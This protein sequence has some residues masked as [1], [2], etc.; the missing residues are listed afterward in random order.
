MSEADIKTGMVADGR[1]N[2]VKRSNLAHL[3]MGTMVSR[4]LDKA[5]MRYEK[6]FG[7]ECVKYAPKRMMCRDRRAK[8]LM[9]ENERDFFVLDVHEVADIRTPQAMTN[10]WGFSVAEAAEVD[11]IRQ[12]AVEHADELGFDTIHPALK[13]HGSYSFYMFDEDHNWWEVECRLGATNDMFFS[14]GDW[15]SDT[16]DQNPVVDPALKIAHTA[17]DVM[18]DEAF[19]THGTTA[20]IACDETRPFYEDILK[21]RT[22]WH[23]RPS[24]CFAGGGD[25]GVIGV[26]SG[27][28]I[29][30]QTPDNRFVLIVDDDKA[31]QEAHDRVSAAREPYGLLEVTDIEPGALDGHGFMLR[32]RDHVWFEISSRSRDTLREIFN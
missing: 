3:A 17:T 15:N 31:L 23:V 29:H 24:H 20:V 26:S 19:M 11:R 18:G 22:V 13:I 1:G 2:L 4:D 21:L 10:H 30:D 16:R 12:Y 27:N 32:T 25:F 7:L 14:R 28:K 5:K 9:N 6:F 8:F